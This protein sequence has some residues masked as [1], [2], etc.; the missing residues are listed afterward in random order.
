MESFLLQ[1]IPLGNSTLGNRTAINITV[2]ESDF[3]YGR[4]QF[5][6]DPTFLKIGE[7]FFCWQLSHLFASCAPVCSDCF[8]WMFNDP[9]WFLIYILEWCFVFEGK[10]DKN[11]RS[12]IIFLKSEETVSLIDPV[13]FVFD[14][15]KDQN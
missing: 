6:E 13:S 9:D 5:K 12:L 2:R 1:L 7:I 11:E 8:Q 3:P 15:K 14:R 4:I 10:K